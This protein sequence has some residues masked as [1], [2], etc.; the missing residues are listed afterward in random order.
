MRIVGAAFDPID[1]PMP[2]RCAAA[3]ALIDLGGNNGV[4]DLVVVE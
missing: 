3:E 4:L 2:R 1:K